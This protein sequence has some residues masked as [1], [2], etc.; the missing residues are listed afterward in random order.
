LGELDF[1]ELDFGELDFGELD[2]FPLDLGVLD[3]GLDDFLPED[4]GLELFG[5]FDGLDLLGL[6][7]GDFDLGVA[8]LFGVFE[9]LLW[10]WDGL[11]FLESFFLAGDF[12]FESFLCGLLSFFFALGVSFFLLFG[13]LV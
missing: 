3:F 7:F 11:A 13:A 4:L 2:F 12:F 10:V 5:D 1:G 9:G 6:L 8:L